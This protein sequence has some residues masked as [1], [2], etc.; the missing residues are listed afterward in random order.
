MSAE[1]LLKIL[2]A[3]SDKKRDLYFQPPEAM[4]AMSAIDE[5][6]SKEAILAASVKQQIWI[7]HGEKSS[8]TLLASYNRTAKMLVINTLLD[9]TETGG[10]S[11][12]F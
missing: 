10:K 6:M 12:G 11:L 8:A 9:K 5:K 1:V 4:E 7:R 2:S 3:Y